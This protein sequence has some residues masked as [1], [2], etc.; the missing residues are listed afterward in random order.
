MDDSK[1]RFC[2]YCLELVVDHYYDLHLDD[3]RIY[4]KVK[5]SKMQVP[6]VKL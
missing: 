3:C 5:A 2:E 4:H 6:L 1:R